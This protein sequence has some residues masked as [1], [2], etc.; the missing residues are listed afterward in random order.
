MATQKM[1]DLN[2]MVVDAK[3]RLAKHI[4]K[5]AEKVRLETA[6]D[7]AESRNRLNIK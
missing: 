4:E 2:K 5:M 3:K 7:F 6:N 1:F